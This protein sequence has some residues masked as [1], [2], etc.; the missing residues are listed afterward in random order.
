MALHIDFLA[1]VFAVFVVEVVRPARI[2]KRSTALLS[3]A[4]IAPSA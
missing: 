2:G 3:M 4:V 1:P